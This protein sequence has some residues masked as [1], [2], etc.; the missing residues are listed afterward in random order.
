MEVRA[1]AKFVRVQ[2]RKVRLVAAE[3]RG[4]PAVMSAH[5]LRFHPSK[6]A[7]CLRKV[8]VSAIAN[9]SENN[10]IAPENLRISRIQVDEGPR[11]K[12]VE[13]RAM[14]RGNRILK[15]MSHITVVVEDFE[16][17]GAVKP[18]GTQAKPRPKF[19]EAK[20]GKKGAAKA[21]KPVA[22]EPEEKI[23]E[24]VDN[25]AGEAVAEAAEAQITEEPSAV[26]GGDVTEI[27]DAAAS[28]VVAEEAAEA[29]EAPEADSAADEKKE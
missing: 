13:Q 28:E 27:A 11:L 23:E 26:E 4:E 17:A 19:G 7:F 29:A 3:V 1:V 12:R 24:T 15:R 25:V 10:G 21:D 22:V 8:L 18:H 20:K 16:P 9:A 6:G 5:K 14:G 2:P